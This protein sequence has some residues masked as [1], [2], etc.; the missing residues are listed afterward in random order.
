LLLRTI[1]Y[2]WLCSLISEILF[3]LAHSSKQSPQNCLSPTTQNWEM[4]KSTQM[5]LC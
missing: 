2:T 5:A 3:L 1:I 4:Y